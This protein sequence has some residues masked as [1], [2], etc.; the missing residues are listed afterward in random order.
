MVTN[1]TVLLT[2]HI[3]IYSSFAPS[4]PSPL[5]TLLCILQ[6]QSTHCV[7]DVPLSQYDFLRR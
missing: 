7:V 5:L 3:A 2:S 6:V 1:A 4:I